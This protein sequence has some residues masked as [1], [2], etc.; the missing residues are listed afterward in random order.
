MATGP[1]DTV[2]QHLRGLVGPAPGAEPS[3][4][5]LLERFARDRDEAAFAA[6]VRRH[7]PLVLGVCRRLLR[8]EQDAEDAF[9]ATFLVLARR[10]G[11][12]DR[13]GSI[14]G[15]LYT[16]AYRLALRARAAAARRRLHESQVALM[17]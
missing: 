7:G 16:V 4:G 11:A 17:S 5:R 9:Q 3:D 13:R 10:A 15:W 1:L 2:L 6:L 14:A 8:Q 12:L